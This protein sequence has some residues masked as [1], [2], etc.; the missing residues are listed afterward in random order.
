MHGRITVVECRRFFFR[1]PLHRSCKFARPFVRRKTLS[2][3]RSLLYPFSA[4]RSTSVSTFPVTRIR[5]LESL[6]DHLSTHTRSVIRVFLTVTA[7]YPIRP[8]VRVNSPSAY[9][10]IHRSFTVV[11]CRLINQRYFQK[12]SYV[13]SRFIFSV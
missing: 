4:V 10:P 8:P 2:S 6:S 12:S 11:R 5:L 7:L 13:S 9:R 3:T 1:S